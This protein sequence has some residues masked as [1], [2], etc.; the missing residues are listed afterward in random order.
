MQANWYKIQKQ[1]NYLKRIQATLDEDYKALQ[2]QILGNL[3]NRL[4]VAMNEVQKLEKKQHLAATT[5]ETTKETRY[6][7]W[8][9][10]L[11]KKNLDAAISEL[12]K[13]Q[14]EFDPTWY[15]TMRI[16]DTLIDTELN[17]P[18]SSTANTLAE[19]AARKI[20][21]SAKSI[22]DTLKSH[23]QSGPSM[24]LSAETTSGFV[25]TAIP[26][27]TASLV[28]RGPKSTLYILDS[29]PSTPGINP[30]IQSR[31][32]RDLARKFTGTDPMSFGLLKCRGVARVYDASSA[33]TAFD[34]LFYI[35]PS[36]RSPQSLRNVLVEARPNVSLSTR[37]HLA[38]Q[39][40]RSLS[41]V[42]TYGFVH[43]GIRP[44]T[45]LIFDSDT[46]KL[47][48]SFLLGF[49]KFRTAEGRT[50]RTGDS[51]WERDLYR[52]PRRQGS[53]PE[54]EYVMQHDIYSLG[55]CL[56]EIGMWRTLVT[57]KNTTDSPI[58]SQLL[59]PPYYTEKN[60]VGKATSLKDSLVV[61]AQ[62]QLPSCMGDKYTD[63]V[64]SCL[65][66]LDESNPD[67]S[68]ESEFRDQDDVI[69]GVRYI[70][71]VSTVIGLAL[72]VRILALG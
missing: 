66:C 71:K 23:P 72:T 52:H 14:E 43:K 51:A 42:H 26:H 25:R 58:P 8:K 47:A 2:D 7:T 32:V 49:E 22:R 35:P 44:E 16:S 19:D 12:K 67:F 50:L 3:V 45:V 48:A 56:L 53:R 30:E 4:K 36:L 9:Y 24:F 38:Q 46:S 11:I 13:W 54:D 15:H 6:R 60:E 55:V 61:L 29:V 40:A 57:Y 68:D 20:M 41:Y 5:Q 1:L 69:I 64:V 70:E 27:S 65:T 63:I 21:S 37:F 10:P 17:E 59:P 62:R 18:K 28:Q 33:I 39:L 34:F 31:D